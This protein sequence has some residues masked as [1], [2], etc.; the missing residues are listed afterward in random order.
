MLFDSKSFGIMKSS[1]D[2]L[3][4]QQ[5]AILHNLANLETPGYK[6]KSVTFQDVLAGEETG[7]A[8]DLKAYIT[9]DDTTSIR[10]DGNNVDSDTESLKL[11]QNYV[12]QLYLYQKISG[13]F[14]NLRY[15]L[16]QS[17]R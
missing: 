1:L 9:T 13:Q 6:A 4:I 12:Q 10:P 14:T 17:T 5:Q 8:Y 11:Y 15:V 16:N 7:G 2:G 3:A